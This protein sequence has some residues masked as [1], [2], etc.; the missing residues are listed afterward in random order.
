[1]AHLFRSWRAT[2]SNRANGANRTQDRSANPPQQQQQ[3]NQRNQSNSQ[4]STPQPASAQQPPPPQ[5]PQQASQPVPNV[6]A[7]RAGA[8]NAKNNAANANGRS[9][10]PV[11]PNGVSAPASAPVAA[12]SQ[13]GEEKYSPV[14]GFSAE[15]VRDYF[16]KAHA[17][18]IAGGTSQHS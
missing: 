6:W 11:V 13:G 4:S 8:S 17:E 15:E 14:G 18:A 16:K 7:N 1:M 2:Q 3:Q 10:T 9:P 12:V 5:Q